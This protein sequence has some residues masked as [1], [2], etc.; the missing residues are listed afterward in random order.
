MSTDGIQLKTVKPLENDKDSAIGSSVGVDNVALDLGDESASNKDNANKNANG[1]PPPDVTMEENSGFV[2]NLQTTVR[3]TYKSH[4]DVIWT[5]I[6]VILIVLYFIYFGFAMAHEKFGDEGSIRLLVCTILFVIGLCWHFLSKQLGNKLKCPDMPWDEEK[7]EKLAKIAYIAIVVAVVLFIIIY[8]I[9]EVAINTTENLVSLTGLAF[10]IFLFFIC[11][12]N[13]A[14]VKWRP[15]FWGLVLQFFFALLILRW[16]FGYQAFQWLGARVSEFL[17]YSDKGAIFVFGEKYTDHFFA[18]KVLTVIVFF[19]TAVSVLYYIGVMQ[20]IIRYIARFMS[21]SMGTSPTESL[22]AA[23]NIFIGQSEAPLLIRP[24][25]KDMTNSELHAVLTG[26]FATIAGSVM[27]AYIAIDVPA[28]HLISASVMSAP[29]ALAMSKLICPETEEGK[30]DPEKVYNM[31]QSPERNVIEAASNGASQSVKLIGNI[32]ANL[33]AFIAVL[34]FINATLDWFGSRVGLE[35]PD[36]EKLSFQFICSYVFYP[37]AAMM[38]VPVGSDCRK[39]AELIGIKTFLNEFVAYGELS[40]YVNNAKNLTWYEGL[41][42]T[43]TNTLMWGE[44]NHTG[45]WH[46]NKWDIVYEDINVTLTKGVMTDRAVVI[47]TYALCGFSNISSM[48]IMLGALGAMA[49]NRKGDLSRLVV[50]AMIAGNVACFMTASIAG[51]FYEGE[52]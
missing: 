49:P 15:V 1:L 7:K 52:L 47:S 2:Y 24:F 18:F 48:G 10:F 23:G 37:V 42:G 9:A 3:T 14:K 32:A 38:G 45:A 39:V 16:P 5:C 41:N 21:W 26:G 4:S 33:I 34:E 35:E 8:I 46:Y 29:A 28:N 51:L 31:E 19:S 11:S 44:V 25:L 30:S 6:Y 36:F 12:R 43:T 50:T 40:T 22:N 27:A 17:A 13:P 20:F